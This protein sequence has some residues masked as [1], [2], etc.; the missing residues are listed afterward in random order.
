MSLNYSKDYENITENFESQFKVLLNAKEGKYTL[1][2]FQLCW[3]NKLENIESEVNI[4]YF[5]FFIVG[6][7]KLI[8]QKLMMFL[9]YLVCIAWLSISFWGLYSHSLLIFHRR[10]AD[11]GQATAHSCCHC[12]LS[13]HAWIADDLCVLQGWKLQSSSGLQSFSKKL[14]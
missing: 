14:L 2:T 7:L 5:F 10:V 11:A 9:V 3:G 1:F 6:K 8:F 13:W 12:W 4:S